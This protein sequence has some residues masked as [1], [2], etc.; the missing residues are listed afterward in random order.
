M[1]WRDWWKRWWHRA[2]SS[3]SELRA[4]EKPGRDLSAELRKNQESPLGRRKHY[5]SLNLCDAAE[6]PTEKTLGLS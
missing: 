5:L 3:G 2:Q 6:E 1:I 4:Q